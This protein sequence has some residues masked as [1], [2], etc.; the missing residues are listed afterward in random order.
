MKVF[1]MTFK[2][3]TR[4]EYQTEMQNTM[5][6]IRGFSGKTGSI[7][8]LLDRVLVS[9]HFNPNNGT[10]SLLNKNIRS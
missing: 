8:N 7:S 4:S 5:L 9:W 2:Y 3:N 6:V 10:K 1:P